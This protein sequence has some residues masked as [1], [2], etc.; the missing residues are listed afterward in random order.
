METLLPL[1]GSQGCDL[2]VGVML[3]PHPY[4]AQAIPL[5]S[6][7]A[8]C[9]LP[10]AHP[11]AEEAQITLDSLR[12]ENFI[13]LLPGSPLRTQIDFAMLSLGINRRTILETQSLVTACRFVHLGAG[14]AL[15]DPMIAPALVGLDVV[16]KP[17]TTKIR[18]SVS[19]YLP[20]KRPMTRLEE[21]FQA[22]L[23]DEFQE[24]VLHEYRWGHSD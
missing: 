9:A 2:A 21:A 11:L 3:D 14:V 4:H 12:E 5:G 7:A 23:A 10:A 24:T 15:V 8:V 1:I 13:D 22:V 18:W 20:E 19:L 17:V 6:C 16:L